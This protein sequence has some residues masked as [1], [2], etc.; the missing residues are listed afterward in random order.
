ML[1]KLGF[2]KF[3]SEMQSQNVKV[4][5]PFRR[6]WEEN[7]PFSRNTKLK[8]LL[9]PF[10]AGKNTID[11]NFKAEYKR[12]VSLTEYKWKP[13]T[14]M[15]QTFTQYYFYYSG[16]PSFFPVKFLHSIDYN[17]YLS[18]KTLAE[19]LSKD[20][21][22][23][24]YPFVITFEQAQ[25]QFKKN[26]TEEMFKKSEQEIQELSNT[27]MI[28]KLEIQFDHTKVEIEPYYLFFYFY[29]NKITREKHFIN[30]LNNKVYK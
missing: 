28:K 19:Y 1:T 14:G 11:T 2:R 16:D 18:D 30:A 4:V 21:D 26:M 27:P 29:Q 8:K 24:V 25:E 5:K 12:P 13:I 6:I 7:L 15:I 9:L 22:T 23:I 10:Y 17:Q 20:Y 3:S